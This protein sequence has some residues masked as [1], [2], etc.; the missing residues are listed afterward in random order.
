MVRGNYGQGAFR[1][2]QYIHQ[3][4]M[5]LNLTVQYFGH[6][7]GSSPGL[8]KA[9]GA[10]YQSH[11]PGEGRE[12]EDFPLLYLLLVKAWHVILAGIGYGFPPGT[13]AL[14][15]DLSVG[16]KSPRPTC[17]LGD[18]GKGSLSCPEIRHVQ[19]HVRHHHTH[20]LQVGEVQ[21]LGHHLGSQ[22]YVDLALTEGPQPFLQFSLPGDA[23]GVDAADAGAGEFGRRLCLD[24]FGAKAGV[25]HVQGAALGADGG[26]CHGPAA[27]VAAQ[28]SLGLV[29]GEG[30][31]AVL[32]FQL[33]VAEVAAEE[34]GEAPSVQ[35][36]D[37]L[38]PFLEGGPDFLCQQGRKAAAV[39]VVAQIHAG[40]LRLLASGQACGKPVALEFS[41]LHQVPGLHR[42]CGAA[43][44][45]GNGGLGAAVHGHLSGVVAGGGAGLV[46]AV[47]LLI[48]DDE[49]QVGYWC[50]YGAADTDDHR[51]LLVDDAP[52]FLEPLAGG[53]VGME[54]G[55]SVP[56]AVHH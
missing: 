52:P 13:E 47:M 12:A 38:A 33:V 10:E 7:L 51:G 4:S 37:G 8:R 18:E 6:L 3:Q 54:D 26:W 24:E 16:K 36:E 32:A 29:V 30:Y 5:L 1:R 25:S 19:S 44:H 48:D 15:D 21:T 50:E 40:N 23:V 20:Q 17:H 41:C 22:Q 9:C 43:H 53:E 49:S 2:T 11:Q 28:S 34:V 39:L 31:G 55:H 27:V 35:E 14:D 56:K 45:Q 42:W 46:G